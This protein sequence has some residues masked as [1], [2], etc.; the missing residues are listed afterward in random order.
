[1]GT[2][3]K[4]DTLVNLN[5]GKKIKVPRLV[6]MHAAE[7]QDVDSVAAGDVVAMFGVDCSSMDTF[8]DGSTQLAMSSMFVP[9]PVM[10]LAVAPSKSKKGGADTEGFGKA[11][12]RFTKED[13]T[14]RIHTD[15]ES[16]QTIVSGMGEL[17]LDVYIERLRREYGVECTVGQPQVN[18]RETITKKIQFD[19]LHKKQTGGSGQYAR[20]MGYIEPL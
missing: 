12:A 5:S 3:N 14:L 19:Y 10:S 4:G 17:H 1:Q 7:M 15:D 13:P 18:Y 9:D 16:Q 2:I 6:R 11:L 8:T 20:I